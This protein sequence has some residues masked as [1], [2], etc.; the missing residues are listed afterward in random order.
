MIELHLQL[1]GS[2][3]V[4][5][6]GTPVTTFPTNKAR[7]LLVFL[8]LEADR[9]HERERLAHVLWPDELPEK[10]LANL[11]QGIHRLEHACAGV[12]LLH[13]TRHAV[14]L[15]PALELRSDVGQLLAAVAAAQAHD[16]RRLSVCGP[17]I[18]A[19]REATALYRGDLLVGFSGGDGLPFDEWL[20]TRREHLRGACAWA[21]AA[22]ATYHEQRG[23]GEA[24]RTALRRWLE[25]E[26]WHEEA[27]QRLITSLA[28]DGQR[29]AVLA[30]F[31]R[32]RR[33]LARELNVEPSSET[34]ELVNK[35]RSGRL[36]DWP[37]PP[38]SVP[39]AEPPLVARE[40]ELAVIGAH[41]ALRHGRLFTLSGPG[42]SGKTRIALAAA[43]AARGSFTDGIF[44]VPLAHIT[45]PDGMLAAVVAA[46][47]L[48][49]Q[50]H[51]ADPVTLL[52][53]YLR[54]R[55]LL[56]VLDNCE[57]LLA[58]ANLLADLLAAAPAL[59]LLVTSRA[60]LRLAAEAVLAVDGLALPPLTALALHQGSVADAATL[61]HV[62][63]VRLF[64]QTAR[65]AAPG[66]A[67]NPEELHA[68]AAICHAVGGLPLA[69]L[70]AAGLVTKLAPAAIL[71]LLQQ[72]LDL[73]TTD[74]RGMPARH[75]SVRALFESSRQLVGATE[76]LVLAHCALFPGTF[77]REAVAAVVGGDGLGCALLPL[78]CEQQFGRCQYLPAT[79]GTALALETLTEHALLQRHGPGRYTLHP[80]VRQFVAEG[81]T[82]LPVA[83]QAAGQAR[84]RTFFLH[85]LSHLADQITGPNGRE[86]VGRLRD[87][88]G[89]ISVAWQTAVAADDY[90]L[91]AATLPGFRT[92]ARIGAIH[93]TR[94]IAL[95]EAIARFRTRDGA[96]VKHLLVKLLVL[97]AEVAYTWGD[98]QALIAAAAEATALAVAQGFALEAAEAHLAWGKGLWR[99][100]DAAGA[101]EQLKD[102]AANARGLTGEISQRLRS[103]IHSY[104][105]LIDWSRGA[106]G[107][108]RA[109]YT[110]ALRIAPAAASYGEAFYDALGGGVGAQRNPR[111]AASY[112]EG[113]ALNTVAL[114][115]L[116]QGAYREAL[117]HGNAAH[118]S[119][120]ATGNQSGASRALISVGLAQ[121]YGWEDL[122]AQE[123]F[124]ASQHR[125]VE[126]G[127]H[128]NA[129]LAAMLGGILLTRLGAYDEAQAALEASLAHGRERNYRWALS[130]GLAYQ[131]LLRHLMGDHVGAAA[132]C[133]EALGLIEQIGDP[134][135]DSYAAT[136]L[137][138]ALAALGRPAEAWAYYERAAT[139]R[140]LIG[141]RHLAPDPLAGLA[142]LAL[143]RGDLA[144]ALTHVETIL[145]ISDTT[146]L[147]GTDEPGRIAV[148]C[149]AVLTAAGDARA[150]TVL[151]TGARS[152][153]ARAERLAASPWLQQRLTQIVAAN[154][155]L[156]M[157]A[158]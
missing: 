73:L 148:V 23:E 21:L 2:F 4:R 68:I 112:G 120:Q 130:F 5:V 26:P 3:Q 55:E 56:L 81:F 76:R 145:S 108:A 117:T 151:A 71:R 30:Q 78:P 43:T 58:G 62:P 42:G 157:L 29:G 41:L 77:T 93:S 123:A 32:C 61:D 138:H 98:Y 20:T 153:A 7:A 38:F 91:I 19:L 52:H 60:A 140:R 118:A 97:Q 83:E 119:Y 82:M 125:C 35:A 156:L 115:A 47:G 18:G 103:S 102:A 11:R 63:A 122:A 155:A 111:T 66:F 131:G 136:H 143:E 90:S 154:V 128:Q 22:L 50:S 70:I 64:L 37:A 1:L 86:A 24:A 25:L 144:D 44:F 40:T 34:I 9:P 36:G 28:R 67:P 33:S 158:G 49:V 94:A 132:S 39:A 129:N 17:C 87:A 89:D 27:H 137:G 88:V 106:F 48:R 51:D 109:H 135:L 107:P 100:G 113:D 127:D 53:A 146:G 8:A 149:H 84:H 31:A 124:V 54:D 85:L 116:A 6:A 150:A 96:A 147:V 110:A 57:Q 16:H 126:I 65:R 152:L 13:T 80:L 104:Q 133:H 114:V 95:T 92:V 59:H 142:R 99:L 15:N 75:Q 79:C 121:M 134:M 14:Q 105:G 46:L 69:L 139:F 10:S 45:T 72:N 101:R 74:W 141:Q 12:A